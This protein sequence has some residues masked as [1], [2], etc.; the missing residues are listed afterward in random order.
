MKLTLFDVA[1]QPRP[2]MIKTTPTN[3]ST[4]MTYLRFTGLVALIII[5]F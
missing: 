4:R 2:I 5:I 3:R 1:M